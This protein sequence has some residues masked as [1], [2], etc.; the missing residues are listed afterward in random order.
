MKMN[1]KEILIAATT[2]P[3]STII[4]WEEVQMAN[5]GAIEQMDWPETM[6]L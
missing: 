1:T 6:V 4:V 3:I 2:A 5:F